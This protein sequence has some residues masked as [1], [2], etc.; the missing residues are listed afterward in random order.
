MPIQ[1][2]Y[3]S[4]TYSGLFAILFAILFPILF[5][6]RSGRV[7]RVKRIGI[8]HAQQVRLSDPGERAGSTDH[9]L[10]VSDLLTRL[11]YHKGGRLRRFF[12]KRGQI[13]DF[14]LQSW[15]NTIRKFYV[16]R[17]EQIHGI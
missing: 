14:I 17:K 15:L 4:Y 10:I 13:L 5:A 1:L 7:R 6:T 12:R 3:F 16:F 8:H 11:S 9:R 2:L